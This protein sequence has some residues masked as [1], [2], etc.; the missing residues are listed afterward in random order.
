M[1]IKSRSVFARAG[2]DRKLGGCQLKHKGLLF[3]MMKSSKIDCVDDYTTL[4]IY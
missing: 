4:Q 2:G 1:E 3:K